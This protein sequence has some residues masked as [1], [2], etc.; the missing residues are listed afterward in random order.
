MYIR[1][2]KILVYFQSA[3]Y[4]IFWF[5]I[6]GIFGIFFD[7]TIYDTETEKTQCGKAISKSLVIL[8]DMEVSG[9]AENKTGRELRSSENAE[10]GFRY[11]I[12]VS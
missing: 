8:C 9:L 12:F 10:V 3:W 1:N 6:Y 5:R 4:I 2:L 11:T 7:D